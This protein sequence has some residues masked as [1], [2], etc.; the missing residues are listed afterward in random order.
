MAKPKTQKFEAKIEVSLAETEVYNTHICAD[1]NGSEIVLYS[2]NIVAQPGLTP[3]NAAYLSFLDYINR[4]LFSNLSGRDR[5]IFESFVEQRK[6]NSREA[7]EKINILKGR[8][9]G[10]VLEY[11]VELRQSQN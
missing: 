1:I 11:K 7:V 6:R 2:T 10:E 5:L 8:D 3:I 9:F 4:G